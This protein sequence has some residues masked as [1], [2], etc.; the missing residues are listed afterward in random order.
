MTIKRLHLGVE[1]LEGR[2]CPAVTLFNGI[3]TL[4]GTSGA[5]TLVVNQ[6]G[7]T[8]FAEGVPFNA[9]LVGRIVI[10]GFGG[11]DVIRNTTTKPSTLYGGMGN[12]KVV[13]G[14]VN[15]VVFGG[16]GNDTLKGRVGTDKLVGGAGTDSLVDVLG[17]D[18]LIR[19][20]GTDPYQLGDRAT[21]HT[22]VN[23][24]RAPAG[25]TALTINP[26]LN[27]A[28][29]MHTQNMVRIGNAYGSDASHR[30]FSTDGA[31]VRD[32]SP[33]LRRVR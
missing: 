17:G 15:D 26:Q 30:T 31:P 19:A 13:G 16:H 12:D 2:D 29:S 14:N 10:T 3:L 8:L 4:T 9:A 27:V 22:L 5:D 18:T 20:A 24:K 6:S 32:R 21:D 33:R 1:S 7:N 25:L 23:E 28:A 11:D